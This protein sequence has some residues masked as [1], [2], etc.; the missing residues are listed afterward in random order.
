MIPDIQPTV[1]ILDT[2]VI[3]PNIIDWK[4]LVRVLK[5][6]NGTR[7]YH[8]PLSID[9]KRVIKCYMDASFA[10]HPN[11]KS[12]TGGI[13]IWKTGATRYGSMKKNL[14]TRSSTDAGVVGVDDMASKS[15]WN[16]FY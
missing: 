16:F 12:H 4:K 2:R 6:L 5:D 1:A 11:F 7:N 14:N 13:M 9:D 10:V 3:S 8:L 15:F